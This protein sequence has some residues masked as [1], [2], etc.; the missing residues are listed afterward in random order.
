MSVNWNDWKN[1]VKAVVIGTSAGGVEVL[2]EIFARLPKVFPVPIVIVIHT[3]ADYDFNF[4]AVFGHCA[5]RVKEAEDKEALVPGTIY[6]APGNYHLSIERDFTFSLSTE[7]PVHFC[8][9]AIDVLFESA[10][11]AYAAGVLGCILTGANTD[12]AEGLRKI[13]AR[14]GKAIVQDPSQA[15]F[16]HMP[17][18]ALALVPRAVVMRA[19]EIADFFSGGTRRTISPTH[20]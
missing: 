12:G 13:V 7:D 2:T 6:F 1:S 9:P 4:K 20:S 14:G 11:D 3:R 10:V 17:E 8:R 5:L 19:E 16:P 15:K 18:S